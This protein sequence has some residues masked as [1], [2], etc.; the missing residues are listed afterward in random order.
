MFRYDLLDECC[1]IESLLL[2]GGCDT[3]LLGRR[4]IKRHCHHSTT[5]NCTVVVYDQLSD[6]LRQ[7][8]SVSCYL[9]YNIA[10][11]PLAGRRKSLVQ[12]LHQVVA[13]VQVQR[14]FQAL[15]RSGFL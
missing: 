7:S 4:K 3:R 13:E 11:R 14:D 15:R 6:Q 9:Q 8:L 5:A 2:C 1:E 12:L 10:A